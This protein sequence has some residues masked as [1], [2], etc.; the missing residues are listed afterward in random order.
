MLHAGGHSAVTTRL[1]RVVATGVDPTDASRTT[2]PAYS[3]RSAISAVAYRSTGSLRSSVLTTLINSALPSAPVSSG[4]GSSSRIARSVS[5]GEARDH[6]C[7]P[8]RISYSM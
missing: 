7:R 5:D 2:D 3:A 1:S 6:G 8:D 4:A